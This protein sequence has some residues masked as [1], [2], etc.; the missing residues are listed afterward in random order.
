MKKS[1]FQH[2]PLVIP[3][4]YCHPIVYN[5]LYH[6]HCSK[7][8]LLRTPVRT[9][10]YFILSRCLHCILMSE[11]GIVSIFHKMCIYDHHCIPSVCT[12][13]KKIIFEMVSY[14]FN[15]KRKYPSFKILVVKLWELLSMKEY[16]THILWSMML[17]YFLMW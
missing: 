17:L 12:L 9:I 7:S 3:L 14:N 2:Y 8:H 1:L 5:F 11:T 10:S 15:Y 6:A 16:R 4:M 13:L